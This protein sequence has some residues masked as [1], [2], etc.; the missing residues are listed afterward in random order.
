M[1]VSD[2]IT[3][4]FKGKASLAEALKEIE[5]VKKAFE[6]TGKLELK[7]GTQDEIIRELQ[8]KSD[9]YASYGF[10]VTKFE[11]TKQS[12]M[13]IIKDKFE[14][15][16]TN[17]FS[18]LNEKLNRS[19][20]DN[21]VSNRCTWVA[22][23][24]LTQN[25]GS[26]KSRIDKHIFSDF[27][28]L[29]TKMKVQFGDKYSEIISENVKIK[30]ELSQMKMRIS[31]VEQKIHEMFVD[32][33][34]G[35]SE[36]Y[37]SQEEND[38]IMQNLNNKDSL[39]SDED[40]SKPEQPKP[41]ITIIEAR[42]D[43]QEN[44]PIPVQ[45]DPVLVQNSD[46][47]LSDTQKYVEETKSSEPV[48][49][50]PKPTV[51]IPQPST[52]EQPKND[53]DPKPQQV[54]P[55]TLSSEVKP[56]PQIPVS[57]PAPVLESQ[58]PPEIPVLESQKPPEIPVLE[59]QK[60]PLPP[61][62]SQPLSNKIPE[63]PKPPGSDHGSTSRNNA[64]EIPDRAPV[65]RREDDT[66]SRHRKNSSGDQAL[67]RK[68]SLSSSQGYGGGGVNGGMRGLN[69]KLTGLQKDLDTFK[70]LIDTNKLSIDEIKEE[71][72]KVYE[73][74]D[75]VRQRCEE[76]E[77]NRQSMELSFIKALRR[78][79]KDKKA[80]G[81]PIGT[82][83]NSKDL[84]K[85]HD[86]INEKYSKIATV[87]VQMEKVNQDMEVIKGNF[88]DKIND[89]INS[90]KGL[91]SFRKDSLKG[92]TDFNSKLSSI[93]EKIIGLQNALNKELQTIKGP[94]SDLISDQ[95]R[96]KE[97]LEENLKRQQVAFRDMVDEC[98][99]SMKNI[100]PETFLQSRI[101]TARPNTRK[102]NDSPR[103]SVKHKFYET[104]NT[105]R[106]SNPN[107]KTDEN[108]LSMYPDGKSLALPKVGV[109]LKKGSENE[110]KNL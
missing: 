17:Y 49:E 65:R 38:N 97:I 80:P 71:F 50:P 11:E 89:I 18:Q 58:K 94:M 20:I 96:E 99:L 22:F 63:P 90:L 10:V 74:I 101:S 108:W 34:L 35:E 31:V 62:Q 76:I 87:E 3:S 23:N 48:V 42:R 15:F 37:D 2:E 88:K 41:N 52:I 55:V 81:K 60:P 27:E 83:I 39:E 64:L 67:S 9:M 105:Y 102:T 6:I 68:N 72:G 82:A 100:I 54:T 46:L 4:I 61:I 57:T 30:D 5:A 84:K 40:E 66:Y 70:S 59:S 12:V 92:S 25:V 26:L 56:E 110:S 13:K 78:S 14:D 91:D 1:S 21:Y 79:G 98:T 77:C 36:D 8:E 47:K 69:K 7:L 19:E 32:D 51:Q 33:G 75:I 85:I 95:Q 43:S 86:L 24:S 45:P 103:I 107:L 29:K 93:D 16:S 109:K 106:I 44:K 53:L 73:K 28:G 104:N